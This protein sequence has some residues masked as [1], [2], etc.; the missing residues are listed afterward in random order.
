MKNIIMTAKTGVKK[1]ARRIDP[2]KPKAVSLP[3]F[4]TK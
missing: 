4:P 2:P 1:T 3:Y